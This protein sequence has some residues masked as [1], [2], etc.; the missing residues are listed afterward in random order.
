MSPARVIEPTYRTIKE[1]L[2]EGAWPPGQRLET[3]RLAED[4]FVSATPVR[5]S[6]N[7]LVGERLIDFRPGEGYSVPRLTE[8]RLRDLLGLSATLLDF[9][10][11]TAPRPAGGAKVALRA[12]D[13]A[14]ILASLC[15][16]IAARSDNTALCETVRGLNDRLH[17]ARR[18]EPRVFPG[19]EAEVEALVHQACDNGPALR[20]S[21]AAYH[22]GR[23]K[24]VG[25]IIA[26]LDNA[27]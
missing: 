14:A 2:I 20:R 17:V 7:R 18:L 21:L 4:L 6:L 27:N 19:A 15:N 9:A 22:A 5:D 25:R 3:G 11:L 23:R 12:G 16:V 8:G 24:A 1:R 10:I 13:H 26:L